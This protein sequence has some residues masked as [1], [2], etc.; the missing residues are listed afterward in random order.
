VLDPGFGF[1]KTVGHNLA[2]LRRLGE[3]VALG[4]PVAIGASRKSTIGALTGRE[5]GERTAGSL[6]AALA[7]VAHGAAIVRVHDVR[8]TVDALKVWCAVENVG[9]S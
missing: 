9:R 6:G 4:F 8:D 7:A 5:V 3:I 1:G 2:L